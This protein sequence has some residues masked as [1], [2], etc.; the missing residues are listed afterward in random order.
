VTARRGPIGM[1]EA[2]TAARVLDFTAERDLVVLMELLGLAWEPEPTPAEARPSKKPTR[3]RPTS[4]VGAA[5]KTATERQVVAGTRTVAEPLPSEPVAPIAYMS[6]KPL[7]PGPPGGGSIAY[8]PIVPLHQLRAAMT[9]IIRRPRRSI[10]VD[11]EAAVE[12]I[13]EKRPLE[14]LPRLTEQ[15]LDGG[16]TIIADVGPEM[17]LFLDDVDHLVESAQHVAGEPETRVCWIED[18]ADLPPLGTEHPVMIISTLG[19]ARA[20]TSSPGSAARW[21]ELARTMI[22]DEIDVTAL[23]PHRRR[24][25][26]HPAEVRFVAWDD[27]PEVGRGRS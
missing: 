27:L 15:T 3:R 16:L 24:W 10:R 12:L 26:N 6:A 25:T 20:P 22:N 23:V 4:P 21:Q 17:L 1:A 14:Q 13:A 7:D 8:E 18:S 11:I 2:L 19:A 5:A 9:M